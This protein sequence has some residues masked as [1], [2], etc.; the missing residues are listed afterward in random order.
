MKTPRVVVHDDALPDTRTFKS[1]LYHIY[2][3]RDVKPDLSR[4]AQAEKPLPDLVLNG[5][6]LLGFDWQET[7]QAWAKAGARDTA[8]HDHG[9]QPHRNGGAR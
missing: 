8:G 3:D 4:R 6:F 1:R 2:N 9:G 7:A 5:Y